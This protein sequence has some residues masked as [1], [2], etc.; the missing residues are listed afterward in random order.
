MYS[1]NQIKFRLQLNK[2]EY[3]ENFVRAVI[4]LIL[5]FKNTNTNNKITNLIKENNI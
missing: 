4:T 2:V 1:L 5:D 3:L